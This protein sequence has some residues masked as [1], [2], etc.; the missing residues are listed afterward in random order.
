MRLL[1]H[2]NIVRIQEVIATKTKI[3]IV[4]EYV[5][6]G[7]LLDKMVRVNSLLLFKCYILTI[8]IMMLQF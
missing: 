2:P 4:M 3:Y 7:Q 8:T 1:H 6:G 5:S